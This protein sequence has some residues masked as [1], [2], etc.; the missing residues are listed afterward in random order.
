MIFSQIFKNRAVWLSGY[1]ACVLGY[2]PQRT[3]SRTSKFF[4]SLT[5]TVGYH[6]RHHRRHL[7]RRS[8]QRCNR[9]AGVDDR[10]I[11]N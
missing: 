6:H 3:P 11:T 10:F 8:C 5:F 1:M 7:S 4:Y 2:C 9:N